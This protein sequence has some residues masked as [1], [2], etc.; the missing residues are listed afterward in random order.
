MADFA[1]G[2][3]RVLLVDDEPELAQT[4]SEYMEEEHDQLSVVT[5]ESARDGIR[6]LD[7]SID[8]IVS[9]YD[10]PGRDGLQFLR[11][12]R[13]DYPNLPFI[14]LTGKGSEEVAAEAVTAGVTDYVRKQ[15]GTDQF[16]VL[17]NR[18]ITAVEKSRA[19]AE[20]RETNERL[21]NL[22]ERITDAFVSLDE[23]WRVTHLNSAAEELFGRE[24][25][26]LMGEVF[27]VAFPDAIG[28]QFQERLEAAIENGEPTTFEEFYPPLFTWLRVRVYPAEGGI[29]LYIRKVEDVMETDEDPR[30]LERQFEA[31]FQRTTD[32]MLFVDDGG[33][34]V[35]VNPAVEELLAL[36]AE[37]LLEQPIARYVRDEE[38]FGISW[39]GI[40]VDDER[41]GTVTFAPPDE[42]PRTVRFEVAATFPGRFLVVL[43]SVAEETTEAAGE[44][45]G[46][47]ELADE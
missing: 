38:G 10:M 7:E 42:D 44:A 8:C 6:K 27:W 17:A 41:A 33:V 15:S 46:E 25:S 19:E 1:G 11:A 5:A 37:K 47:A 30:T 29:S 4:A 31:V 20:A 34:T 13:D 35:E 22:F 24:E 3:M 16:E 14:L 45:H 9:D 12:I 21:R 43:E 28:T 40:A 26:P 32:A 36:P 18:I 39:T 2:V 23:D